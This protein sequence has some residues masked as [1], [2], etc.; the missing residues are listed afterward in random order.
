MSGSLFSLDEG[1]RRVSETPGTSEVSR[2]RH[3]VA[4]M[5]QAHLARAPD[6]VVKKDAELQKLI[7]TTINSFQQISKFGAVNTGKCLDKLK[8]L[9]CEQRWRELEKIKRAE[10]PPAN[11]E[12]LQLANQNLKEGPQHAPAGPA[13]PAAGCAPGSAAAGPPAHHRLEGLR[14][15]AGRGNG[16]RQFAAAQAGG[17]TARA[18]PHAAGVTR[19]ASHVGGPSWGPLPLQQ[20][21][22][23]AGAA[24]AGYATTSGTGATRQCVS[25]KQAITTKVQCTELGDLCEACMNE[26][27]QALDREAANG[28]RPQQQHPQV[29]IL[30]GGQQGG[31][32]AAPGRRLPAPLANDAFHGPAPAPGGRGRS[33]GVTAGGVQAEG[34]PA[35]R[36]AKATREQQ[37]PAGRARKGAQQGA[38]SD[39]EQE[40]V[41]SGRGRGGQRRS[42]PLP[43]KPAEAIDLVESSDEEG[44]V[45]EGG[46]DADD[47]GAAGPG[48]SST[49][50]AATAAAR[51]TAKRRGSARTAAASNKFQWSKLAE[52]LAGLK[53]VY[54]P[55]GGKHYV[56]VIAE[57]LARLED[58]EFLND[59]C[60]DFYIKYI[61]QH[62]PEEVRARYHFFN[63]F[64]LK[65][66]QE[67]AAGARPKAEERA[68]QDHE[69]VK[70]WTKHVDLFSKDYV[71]VP[72]HGHL[73]WSLM[74]VCHPGNIVN[75]AALRPPPPSSQQQ[76]QQ[77]QAEGGE[78]GT[79][80]AEGGSG[81]GGEEASAKPVILHLDSLDGSHSPQE[82]FQALRSYLQQE[83]QRKADDPNHDSAPRRWKARWEASGRT[84][85]AVRFDT[86]L[87]PGTRM[88]ERLPKQDNHTDCG[89]F[90]LAY[91]DFFTSANP[92]CVALNGGGNAADVLP[93]DVAPE[94]AD[95]KSFM[96]RNWF[97][98]AN[99]AKWV[100]EGRW[101]G[102][103]K[104]GGG[105]EDRAAVVIG[106][107]TRASARQAAARSTGAGAVAT[108][109]RRR[110]VAQQ[111]PP[112]VDLASPDA[113]PLPLRLQ[114]PGAAAG[115]EP[116]GDE[117]APGSLG[118]PPASK[119][120]KLAPRKALPG[121]PA[122][123][124]AAAG[125][126][127]GHEQMEIILESE[128]D[129]DGG[130]D[131]G[132]AAAAA[133]GACAARPDGGG[134]EEEEEED[135]L[136]P[137]PGRQ[138]PKRRRAQPAAGAPD[139]AGAAGPAA[140]A[141]G[142]GEGIGSGR[143]SDGGSDG[144]ECDP[145]V[146]PRTGGSGGG[147]AAALPPGA[148]V[149]VVAETP[150]HEQGR[151]GGRG[152]EEEEE[153]VLG[154]DDEGYEEGGGRE[155]W[156]R[157]VDCSRG[158]AACGAA[159]GGARNGQRQAASGVSGRDQHPGASGSGGGPGGSG[160]GGEAEQQQLLCHGGRPSAGR[161]SRP[162]RR[163]GAAGAAGLEAAAAADAMEG[164]H[165]AGPHGGGGGGGPG[166]D[167][168]GRSGAAASGSGVYPAGAG[169]SAQPAANYPLR[170]RHPQHNAPEQQRQLQV[171]PLGGR[172]QQLQPQPPL[173]T[174]IHFLDEDDE[175][176]AVPEPPPAA[177]PL[178]AAAAQAAARGAPGSPAGQQA[179]VRRTKASAK[180]GPQLARSGILPHPEKADRIVD[181]CDSPSASEAERGPGGGG[182]Q[183]AVGPDFGVKS[184]EDIRAEK[185]AAALVGGLATRSRQAT[186]G[187][188]SGR[189]GGGGGVGAIDEGMTED[190]DGDESASF[191]Y[192]SPGPKRARKME[193]DVSQLAPP[194]KAGGPSAARSGRS[195]TSGP[196]P[197]SAAPAPGPPGAKSLRA[198][199]APAAAAAGAAAQFGQG[200]GQGARHGNS[201]FGPGS[202]CVAGASGWAGGKGN[203]MV[204]LLAAATTD[205]AARPY[206]AAVGP[207]AVAAA[208][209]QPL[210]QPHPDGG[211]GARA[212][213]PAA[214]PPQPPRGA[215]AK[216]GRLGG[217]PGSFLQQ[218]ALAGHV[219]KPTESR[220]GYGRGSDGGGRAQ[221]AAAKRPAAST[222]GAGGAAAT[223]AKRRRTGSGA[224]GAA[225]DG[226]RQ[227]T[228]DEFGPEAR[229]PTGHAD[230][231]RWRQRQQQPAAATG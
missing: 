53:C 168:V 139:R 130:A 96:Q 116:G 31:P 98:K 228:L 69:R 95:P 210:P 28:R 125:P 192:G 80:G 50:A 193:L 223:A 111:H 182:A 185:A 88:T 63:T 209:A 27:L 41:G 93:L 57:D 154:T 56:E 115:E 212:E 165:L 97:K 16:A 33:R 175:A 148:E 203:T 136:G 15:H 84:P 2:I 101:E 60:I 79:Q 1:L 214:A 134:E 54:P 159:A 153:E 117:G 176:A 123:A 74:L 30:K 211:P 126:E 177:P 151:G 156:G 191:G 38:A 206:A 132:G 24:A 8:S 39:G 225:A 205:L 37:Q 224:G 149:D 231:P 77:Q 58:G 61:E 72:I 140:A 100:A 76:Q 128:S 129:G 55:E 103:G 32:A 51:G 188:G 213:H 47:A 138:R 6:W 104:M 44:A 122:S 73:H 173:N 110:K 186:P 106:P 142:T 11:P 86:E 137:R 121:E 91:M 25:C 226:S 9:L 166:K 17:G 49:A 64:F 150:L 67:K 222:R 141:G 155:G 184:R 78:G 43:P 187:A 199:A 171:L 204:A 190:D 81:G 143:E 217:R 208:A 66:L 36:K 102:V 10:E 183:K 135:T 189:G 85:P 75:N 133:V 194:G 174:H 34:G 7:D 197:G 52:Q 59:T 112:C 109:A 167:A 13:G 20:T 45:G 40:P 90:L 83:W 18:G 147:G 198:A 146:L 65:K 113:S 99:A 180:V 179:A 181:Y 120:P 92:A 94:A 89:L 26:H 221:R 131:G 161:G 170:N 169:P 3:E 163:A 71:F 46:A 196:V 202:S 164:L 29:P 218:Q 160:G 14:P 220:D 4:R 207:A 12:F 42:A 87:L 195:P 178:P 118:P 82:I 107:Q 19:A 144:E 22:N 5:P 201:Q 62:L 229:A 35:T 68:R 70:K 215:Q 108:A 21:Q 172:Q 124:A 145:E 48:P 114:L 105:M 200:A 227:Q 157:D 23:G 158:A 216:P 230:F 127:L 152:E 162:R 219:G 119:R